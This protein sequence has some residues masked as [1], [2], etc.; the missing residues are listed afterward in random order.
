MIKAEADLKGAII[1]TG[2]SGYKELMRNSGVSK[3]KG[4]VRMPGCNLNKNQ[5]K[6]VYRAFIKFK[7]KR[8][9]FLNSN[10]F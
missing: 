7:K 4:Y 3:S 9:N 5:E 2:Y 6:I 10:K 8:E 1:L